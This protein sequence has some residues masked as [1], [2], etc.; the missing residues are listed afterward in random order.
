[1][2]HAII[3]NTIENEIFEYTYCSSAPERIGRTI[4][5]IDDDMANFP[6]EAPC[7]PYLRDDENKPKLAVF[8]I[9]N[10]K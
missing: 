4:L 9:G 10:L 5:A 2:L 8:A 3:I 7:R 1:M 6:C